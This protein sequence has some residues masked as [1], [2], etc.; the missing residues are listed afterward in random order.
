MKSKSR[1]KAINLK[2]KLINNIKHKKKNSTTAGFEPARAKPSR[3]LVYLL[4]HSDKLS[5]LLNSL[6][7][8]ITRRQRSFHFFFSVFENEQGTLRAEQRDRLFD[9]YRARAD[10]HQSVR[11]ICIWFSCSF[12]GCDPLDKNAVQSEWLPSAMPIQSYWDLWWICSCIFWEFLF[13]SSICFIVD[14]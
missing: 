14:L 7:F 10:S 9:Q 5:W 6:Y 2:K 13:L 12:P 4:N 1:I 11:E 8:I 3:F